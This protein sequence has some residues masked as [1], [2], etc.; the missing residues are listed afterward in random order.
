MRLDAT[1]L[2]VEGGIT[3]AEALT[4][5]GSG[6]GGAGALTGT[7]SS[8]VSGA[9]TLG[10]GTPTVGVAAGPDTLTLSGT[11]GGTSLTKVGVGT[12]S[13]TNA[14]NY[15]GATNVNEGVLSVSGGAG[16]CACAV[17]IGIVPTIAINRSFGMIRF[18]VYS[19]RNDSRKAAK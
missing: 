13:L 11:V 9:I 6:V 2:S 19:I 14:N 18:I 5:D 17:L 16:R 8:T 3:T 1:T 10:T 7:G 15:S 12:L 4:L